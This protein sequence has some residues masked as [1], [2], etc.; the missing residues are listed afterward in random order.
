M[1]RQV[2]SHTVTVTVSIDGGPSRTIA[3]QTGIPTRAT[4]DRMI[5][6]VTEAASTIEVRAEDFANP[7]W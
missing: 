2:E 4:A 6:S 3:E 7:Y 1:T 5:D